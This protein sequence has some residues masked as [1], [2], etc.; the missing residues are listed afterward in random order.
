MSLEAAVPA[1]II[2]IA[3][4]SFHEAAHAWAADR[5]G[6]PTARILGR[7]TLNPLA[8]ID[9]IGTVLFPLVGMLSGLSLIGWAKPVPVDMRNLKAPR[10]DFAL[11]ALA[12]PVSNVVLA[13][14]AAVLLK[15]QGGIVPESGQTLLTTTLV[16]AVVMN[17]SLAIFNLLPIPPLDGGNVLAGFVPEGAARMIDRMRPYGFF[18]LYALLLS[19]VLTRFVFPVSDSIASWLL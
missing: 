2:L 5:L 15:A 9:W 6:D 18:L 19:G 7:L 11:V 17:V 16:I 14:A 3:S 13:L 4:L 1:F 10:R 12:G 8:H